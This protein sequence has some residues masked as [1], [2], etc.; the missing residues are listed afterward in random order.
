[1]TTIEFLESQ[2]AAV[3]TGKCLP[4]QYVEQCYIALVQKEITHDEFDRRISGIPFC[5]SLMDRQITKL[6]E[7]K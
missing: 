6:T 2:R 4:S 7:R 1:M 3:G 5:P